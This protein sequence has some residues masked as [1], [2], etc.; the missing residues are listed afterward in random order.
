V[1]RSTTNHTRDSARELLALAAAVPIKPH[2]QAYALEDVNR[3]IA[4]LRDG[5]VLGAAVLTL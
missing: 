2:V 3:A 5:R 1:I 4:D